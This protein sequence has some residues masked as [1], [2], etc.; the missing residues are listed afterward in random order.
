MLTCKQT[1][2]KTLEEIS[3]IFGDPV[4]LTELVTGP[5]DEKDR[6]EHVERHSE[7]NVEKEV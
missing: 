6:A 2:G 7:S 1:K 5:M 3:V 4:G